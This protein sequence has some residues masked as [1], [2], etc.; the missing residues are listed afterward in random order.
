MRITVKGITFSYNSAPILDNV[1]FSLESG[2]ILSILGPNGSGKTTLLKVLASILS[3]KNGAVFLD[4]KNLAE[5]S[6]SGKAKII[7]YVPQRSEGFNTS[8][9]EA[10]LS[11]R[12]P[13]V[14]FRIKKEDIQI[15]ERV[16]NVMG[17]SHLKSKSIM[18]ISGG[19][20]QKVIIARALA[21]NPKVLLLDEPLTYL[22]IKNQFE[23]ASLI[24]KATKELHLI[25]VFVLHDI[26]LALRYS[27]VFLFLKEGRIEAFGGKEIISSE[28]IMKVFGID[29]EI[30]EMMGSPYVL[31]KNG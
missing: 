14:H 13:H 20:F 30:K 23:M 19:E 15:T 4:G 11:G 2:Q 24:S 18:R 3:P 25:T 29:V 5:I 7:G 16:I 10:V 28:I 22:D 1:N 27:D 12:K 9:F 6:L 21:Q 8:V 26:N 17:L 31:I